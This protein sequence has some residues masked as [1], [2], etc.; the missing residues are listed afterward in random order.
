ML[1]DDANGASQERKPTALGRGDVEVVARERGLASPAS[2]ARGDPCA[3]VWGSGGLSPPSDGE[4][5]HHPVPTGHRFCCQ[6]ALR[7]RLSVRIPSGQ[8][9][10]SAMNRATVARRAVVAVLP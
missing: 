3:P 10:N 8:T 6:D 9:S 7:L 5:S 2:V 1:S 4:G